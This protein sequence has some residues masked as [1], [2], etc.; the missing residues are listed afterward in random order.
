M[1]PEQTFPNI[2]YSIAFYMSTFIFSYREIPGAAFTIH[3][4]HVLFHKI[5][6]VGT[7]N[8]KKH[9]ICKLVLP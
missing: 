7:I 8:I 1:K 3:L 9:K 2:M 4:V 6:A 5:F